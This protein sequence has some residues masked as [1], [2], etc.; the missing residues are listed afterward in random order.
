MES[1]RGDALR[2]TFASRLVADGVD[3]RTVQE[4][5]GWRTLSMVQRYTHLSP[6]YL[7]AAV[8]KIVASTTRKQTVEILG[9]EGWPSPVEGVRLEIG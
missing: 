3:L 8:E 9:A 5:G 2:H 6:G 1:T 4:L 7:A